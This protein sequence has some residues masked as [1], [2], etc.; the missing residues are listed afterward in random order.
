M[1]PKH[2]VWLLLLLI[3]CKSKSLPYEDPNGWKLTG[4]LDGYSILAPFDRS[5]ITT[6]LSKHIRGNNPGKHLGFALVVPNGSVTIWDQDSYILVTYI[7]DGDT[8]QAPSEAYFFGTVEP[9][10]DIRLLFGHDLSSFRVPSQHYQFFSTGRGN[11]V[12]FARFGF[13]EDQPDV[14]G[15]VVLNV[16]YALTKE[17]P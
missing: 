11:P 4:G 9:D 7:H 17:E 2:I 8:L 14:V 5:G 10:D 16:R 1:T 3:S 15:W 6:T 13:S 12:V